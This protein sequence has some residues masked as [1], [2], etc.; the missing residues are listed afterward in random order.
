MSQLQTQRVKEVESK[1]KIQDEEKR[2]LVCQIELLRREI[3]AALLDRDRTIKEAH[4]LREKL[5]ERE[6]SGTGGKSGNNEGEGRNDISRQSRLDIDPRKERSSASSEHL[7]A[8]LAN[9]DGFD[10]TKVENLEQAVAEIERLRKE[11]EKLQGEL[12]AMRN[13]QQDN[14]VQPNNARLEEDVAKGRRDWA[15]SE[16]DKVVKERESIRTLCDKLRRERDRAVSELAEALRDLDEVKKNRNEVS[17]E[18]KDL[19]ERI[20]SVEKDARIRMLQRSVGQSH[21]RDSAIDTDLQDWETETL[22][23]DM[24]R[25]SN[26][27]DLGLDLTG[28]RRP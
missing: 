18:N 11:G 15:Y 26:D 16:G 2:K 21:S 27:N 20:E 13:A 24:G 9:K 14:V 17:K 3:D 6:K 5:G 25:I 23:I 12:A 8:L 4:E 22:D 1:S 19:R 7:A 10:R 28:K